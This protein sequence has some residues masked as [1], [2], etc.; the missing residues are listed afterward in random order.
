MAKKKADTKPA[1]DTNPQ[2]GEEQLPSQYDQGE[3][4]NTDAQLHGDDSL[5]AEA[6]VVDGTEPAE[7]SVTGSAQAESQL[8]EFHRGYEEALRKHAV[9][10]DGVHML[11]RG[12]TLAEA[13]E[14]NDGRLNAQLKAL[15]DE[16][17]AQQEATA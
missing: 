16:E 6:P 5:P 10:V 17:T 14:H 4:P 8:R 12:V 2:D 13:L 7:A 9:E 1:D 3:A 15:R 11:P